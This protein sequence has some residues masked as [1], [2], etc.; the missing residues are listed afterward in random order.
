MEYFVVLDRN[1]LNIT[2]FSISQLQLTS[3]VK[4]NALPQ[5][6]NRETPGQVMPD[7]KFVAH[8]LERCY[9]CH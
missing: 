8:H 6:M 1:K 9:Y 3:E 4:G 5:G 7:G 2:A